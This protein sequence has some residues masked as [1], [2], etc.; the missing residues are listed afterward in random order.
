MLQ[1][2]TYSGMSNVLRK[3]DVLDADQFREALKTYTPDDVSIGDHGGDINAFDAITR[4]AMT[5]NHSI[6]ISGGNDAGRYRLS[7]GYLDQNGVIK[8]SNL[9]KY[10]ANLNSNFTFLESKKLGLDIDLFFT[11]TNE[12]IPPIDV[13]VGFEGNV[14]SQALNWNPTRPLY[15]ENGELTWVSS[16]LINPLASLE[17]YKDK[18]LVNRS[19]EHTSELQSR[20]H[21]V[22]RLL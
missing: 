17:A 20:G 22:C 13:D 7:L 21:L 2:S 5:Q 16:N 15:D 11:Q 12:I 9:P 10:T 6:A 8:N 3:L 14:I 1:F 19:E 18:A 4:T